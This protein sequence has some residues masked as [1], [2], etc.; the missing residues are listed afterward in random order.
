M[1]IN[2][3]YTHTHTHTHTHRL[4]AEEEKGIPL[5]DRQAALSLL[6][7]LSLQRGTLSHILD[8]VLLLLRLSGV[9][10]NARNIKTAGEVKEKHPSDSGSPR[11][12]PV[13]TS[14]PLLP[15]LRRL[16]QVPTPLRPVSA[17]EGTSGAQALSPT[18]RYLEF[19][20][21]P[22]DDSTKVDLQQVATVT[23]SHL[24]RIAEPY[25]SIDMVSP[26]PLTMMNT[27]SLVMMS[28]FV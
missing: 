8:S 7:E 23:L 13:E 22:N 9:P 3:L 4:K 6:L 1:L 12:E 10:D 2:Y 11:R 16:D 26:Y 28:S 14:Y 17:E 27:G 20:T 5:E 15:F 18:R 19:L 21:L 25:Y 24:D